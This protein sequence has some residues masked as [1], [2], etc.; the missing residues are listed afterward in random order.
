MTKR[1]DLKQ[2]RDDKAV[3]EESYGLGKDD[4]LVKNYLPTRTIGELTDEQMSEAIEM[5]R[6]GAFESA[7]ARVLGVD[8]DVF[9]SALKK[10]KDGKT[11]H[12]GTSVERVEFAR[13]FYDARKEHMKKNLKIISEERV[14]V[15][16]GPQILSLMQ[17][18]Q[19]P[20]EEARLALEIP[21]ESV[22]VNEYVE[23]DDAA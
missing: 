7:I 12:G 23:P 16:A 14:E 5:A 11:G 3:L 21:S 8:V 4:F 22:V 2:V 20:I 10:G 6:L 18:A 17:L 15:E 9:L 1:A 19:I 13:K